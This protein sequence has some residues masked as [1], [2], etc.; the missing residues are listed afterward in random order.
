MIEFRNVSFCYSNSE[1]GS[2]LKNINLTIYSGKIVLL[3][4]ESG[5][6]KTS[7]TRLINGLAPQFYEGNLEGKVLVNGIDVS[8]QPIYDTAKIVGSVFQ[9]PRTQFFNVDTTSELIFGCENMGWNLQDILKQKEKIVK[10]FQ[11]QSLMDKSIFALSGGEKQKIACASVSAME[12]DII[13]LDEPSSSLDFESINDL[14]KIIAE[15]KNQG[16]TVVIAEHRIYYLRGLL[17][18]VIYMRH[19]EIIRQMTDKEFSELSASQLSELGL[20]A[21]DLKNI[22]PHGHIVQ[23]RQNIKIENFTFQYKD[24]LQSALDIKYA[25]LPKEG[26]IAVI[27]HNGAGKSTF[28]KCLC[29]LEKKCKG[30]LSIGNTVMSSKKRLKKCYMVM[31][32]VNYQLFTESVME[33]LLISMVQEDEDNAG[34]ILKNLD[35]LQYK[36]AHPMSISGGQKQRVAIASAIASNREIIIFDEPTSGLD[37]KHMKKVAIL[38]NSLKEQR[39]LLF[40]ITH[41]YELI[42]E[43]CTHILEIEKGKVKNNYEITDTEIKKL[44]DFFCI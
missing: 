12:P 24:S 5:C 18:T 39:K 20:R 32:D 2:A 14:R 34:K 3:C 35:L 25:E 16:K 17:D 41:D 27:G 4:G 28:A 38:L 19:G 15:W 42:C 21:Y 26:I 40:L 7:I 31:Q 37:L 29:G 13:V 9:N 23:D 8:I 44:R 11:I 36:D 22:L 33:E 1:I 30:L 43:C 6:G 10:Q